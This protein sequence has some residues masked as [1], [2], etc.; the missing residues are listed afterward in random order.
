MEIDL[1]YLINRSTV[2]L[3]LNL[4]RQWCFA[5]DYYLVFGSVSLWLSFTLTLVSDVCMFM[6][7]LLTTMCFIIFCRYGAGAT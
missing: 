5:F 6:I 1:S 2:F 7:L 3:N 4:I